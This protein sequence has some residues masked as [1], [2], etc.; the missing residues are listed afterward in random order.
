MTGS[1]DT[2]SE[3][4]NRNYALK[5]STVMQRKRDVSSFLLRRAAEV[6]CLCSAVLFATVSPVQAEDAP[7]GGDADLAQELSNP[8]ADLI[9]LPFQ[10]NF[11]YNIGPRDDGKKLQTNIQPVIPFDLNEDWNLITRTILPVIYQD[12]VFPGAGSQ[13]GLGDI[14]ATL[15]FSPKQ[16]TSGGVMWGVGP[17]LLLP[18]AS[19][20][21]LGGEKWGAGPSAIALTVRGPWTMG[22]LANHVWSYAGAGG[23]SDISNTLVQPFVAYTWPSA[24]TASVQSETTYNWKAEDWA[25]PINVAVSKLVRWGQLPVSLQAGVGYWAES[26]AGGPEDWRFRLQANFV[27]PK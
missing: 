18:T 15:F 16:P 8:I 23:R 5:G 12:D 4:V 26:S 24:W 11:D 1:V 9:T 3:P 21:L 25:M 17:V 14:N 6:L 27:L 2:A 22:V 7:R 20:D 19:D 10:M 13:F